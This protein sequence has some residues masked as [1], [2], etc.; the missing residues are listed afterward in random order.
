M[1]VIRADSL[2]VER[3][4]IESL[5]IYGHPVVKKGEKGVTHSSVYSL[6]STAE[7]LSFI[8]IFV[9]SAQAVRWI[10][11]SYC[12]TDFSQMFF[13]VTFTSITVAP[14]WAWLRLKSPASPLF[15]Q[16]FIRAQIK[17][18]IKAPRHR[19][20]SHKWPVTRK[21]LP[22]DDVIMD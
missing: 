21:K 14:Q 19:T 9:F 4:R 16:P 10:F 13:F 8:L 18:N 11:E 5:K 22:F 12:D 7:K 1:P 3:P 2:V 17:E 6:I 20:L 15:T